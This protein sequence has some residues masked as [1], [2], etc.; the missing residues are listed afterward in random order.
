MR[1]HLLQLTAFGAFAGTVVL[2]LDALAWGGLFLLH[3]ETGAGKT[4]LLDGI[5][6]ALFGR[7]PGPRA[8]AKRL[9]SDHAA[10]DVRTSVTL[11][12]SLAGRRLRITRS[13]EQERAR[14]RG[15]GTT[16]EPAKVLLEEQVDGTWQSV[17]TRVGEADREIADLVGMSAEQFYSVVLLPQGD[18][19]RFLRA[20]SDERAALLERLFGTDR[21]RSVEHWLADRRRT[22]AAA[23]DA[24]RDSVTRLAA[25]VAQVAGV[26]EPDDVVDGWAG[27]LCA[28]ASDTAAAAQRDALRQQAALDQALAAAEA[29]SVLADRQQRR[30]SALAEQERLDAEAAA[31]TALAAELD[32]A[33]RAAECSA[34]LDDAAARDDA[35]ATAVALVASRRLEL[36]EDGRCASVE[37][38]QRRR[39]AL[40]ERAGRLQALQADA[41]RAAAEQRAAARAAGAAEAAELELA[42][43]AR[44]TAQLPARR[45]GAEQRRTAAQDAQVRV[46]TL[47]AELERAVAAVQRARELA[48]HAAQVEPLRARHIAAREAA[49]DA[50]ELAQDLRERRIDGMVGELAATLVAGDPC[51]VCG[52]PD[53]PDPAEVQGE[54]VDRER[55]REAAGT[56]ERLQTEAGRLGNELAALEA[57]CRAL[58]D[59]AATTDADALAASASQA[60][61]SRSA[62]GRSAAAAQPCRPSSPPPSPSRRRPRSGRRPRST[63]CVPSSATPSTSRRLE[64]RSV[65]RPPRSRPCWSRR[66]S[67]PPRCGRPGAPRPPPRMPHGPPAST[68]SRPPGPRAAARP[69]GSRQR[70]GCA[71]T[72]R[73]ARRSAPRWPTLTSTSPSSHLPTC[74]A[75]QPRSRPGARRTPPPWPRPAGSA[76]APTSWPVW[77]RS[78]RPRWPGWRR[79]PS[80]PPRSRRSP[81]SPLG[82]GPTRCA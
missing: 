37:Q 78:S 40:G 22:S 80:A 79:W 31:V 19:A 52:S 6:F 28:A 8:T 1:P 12:V 58:A 70:P 68:T 29:A 34:L 35:L 56:A 73:P 49:A 2:D 15:S 50:R 65:T 16:R 23:R 14:L 41:D 62:A 26:D 72:A 4:T 33:V 77:C 60:S 3:G 17:S 44:A 9:R 21:F 36:P 82:R 7:V 67:T 66:S 55:E 24:A 61:S 38:L 32:D 47:V 39:D 53:H 69:G 57:T 25:R 48:A 46:P 64:R 59:G 75:P 5:G 20:G 76:T 51:L 74:P 13:P 63:W 71:R 45:A 81:T 42:E 18:F 10:P 11:E 54:A 43:L 27:A 30:R